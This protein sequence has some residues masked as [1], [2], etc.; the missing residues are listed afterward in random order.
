MT[1]R[2]IH[3]EEGYTLQVDSPLGDSFPARDYPNDA[4]GDYFDFLTYGKYPSRTEQMI[5]G[6]QAH[7]LEVV[8][9]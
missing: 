8:E 6:Y 2:I 4:R 1:A 3:S 7:I 9:A 5:A